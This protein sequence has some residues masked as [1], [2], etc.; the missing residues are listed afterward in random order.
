LKVEVV[1]AGVLAKLDL[2][3][4]LLDTVG[5]QLLVHDRC[6]CNENF[7]KKTTRPN[8]YTLSAPA[9]SR[10]TADDDDDDDDDTVWS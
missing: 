7:L 4:S 5:V 1:A 6:L 3:A 10:V 9:D 2:L 8:V